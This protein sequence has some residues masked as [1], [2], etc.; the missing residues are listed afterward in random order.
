MKMLVTAGAIALVSAVAV[1]H[2]M[3]ADAP[4]RPEGVAPSEWAP[5]SDTLGIVLVQQ[6]PDP[7]APPGS[8]AG[9]LGGAILSRPENGYFMIKRA[10]RWVR[11]VLIEPIKG[12][13]GAG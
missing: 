5:V 3:G 2:A 11:L 12:P 4:N 10:G 9:G 1:M 13:G 8:N 7:I 6:T